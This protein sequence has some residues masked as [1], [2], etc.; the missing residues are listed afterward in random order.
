[1]I[2]NESMNLRR[3]VLKRII[4]VEIIRKC[5]L[6][7]GGKRNKAAYLLSNPELDCRNFLELVLLRG[8][9]RPRQ[10]RHVP[11]VRNFWGPNIRFL[12]F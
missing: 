1:M 2:G 3:D 4:V 6:S 10:P 11:R 8:G 5:G 9:L 7:Y 12:I